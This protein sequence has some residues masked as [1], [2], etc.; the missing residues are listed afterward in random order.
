MT[1]K[2]KKAL[3]QRMSVAKPL[4]M[5]TNKPTKSEKKAYERLLIA[6]ETAIKPTK[7]IEQKTVLPKLMP[8]VANHCAPSHLFKS[9]LRFLLIN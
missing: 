6:E 8:K 3:M 7:A 9:I 4:V 2:E 1:R 5:I